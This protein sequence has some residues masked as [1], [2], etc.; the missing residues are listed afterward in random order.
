MDMTSLHLTV[1]PV[2]FHWA[3]ETLV[4]FYARLADEAP[5][6][7]VVV[8]E[9]VCSKRQPFYEDKLPAAIERLQRAG[10]HVAITSLALPTLPRELKAARSM[11]GSGIEVE[12]NDLSSLGAAKG[13][14][15]SVG[16]LINVYNEA[17]LGYLVSAGAKRV[18]LPPELPFA[19][20]EKLARAGVE[21][22]AAV[23]VWAYG[24]PPL[25]ISA[26]CYHARI[27][28]LHKDS[29]KF[30][31]GGDPD[32]LTVKTVDGRDFLAVNGVQTLGDAYVNLIG[33]A[34]KLAGAGVAALRLS[35]HS[36]DF[37]AL[38]KVFRAAVSGELGG[39]EA[40]AAAQKLAP[41]A[42]FTHGF[43]LGTSGAE[44]LARA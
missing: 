34:V 6:D 29:C 10:K 23:E 43:L 28:G 3:P 11:F 25:A 2:L 33:D 27:H 1:G 8:G 42:G 32:G 4:D 7:R 31:C 22:G 39:S 24:R 5:V 41:A 13:G 18:C 26:R 37:V 44:P 36:G 30:V 16:P 15:F 14:V 35:P 17:T 20:V 12:L 21:K 38:T 40:L 19:S 9:V